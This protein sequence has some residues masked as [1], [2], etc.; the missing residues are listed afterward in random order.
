MRSNGRIINLSEGTDIREARISSAEGSNVSEKLTR[1]Y[2]CKQ[3][4][5]VTSWFRFT[6][7]FDSEDEKLKQAENTA[8]KFLLSTLKPSKE[9][10]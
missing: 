7:H 1:Y 2:L 3:G 8:V 10:I 4:E 9:N 6:A 5:L